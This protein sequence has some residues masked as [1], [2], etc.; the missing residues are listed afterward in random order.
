VF[1]TT[2][3]FIKNPETGS[4][5]LFR[6]VARDVLPGGPSLRKIIS[7]AAKHSPLGGF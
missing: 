4:V 7:V 5:G 6:L 3:Q 2:R 1:I